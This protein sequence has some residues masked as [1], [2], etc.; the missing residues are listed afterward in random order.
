MPRVAVFDLQIQ[1]SSRILRAGTHGR[2]I[3][4]TALVNPAASTMQFSTGSIL[5]TEGTGSQSVDAPV[6]VTRSGDTSF[7]ASVNYATSDTSGANGCGQNTGAASSR[8]DYIATSGTLNFAAGQA[9]QTI[10]I[11]ITYD[12]Y[13][14]GPET[15]TLTLS[16]PTGLNAGLGLPSTTA[17]TINDSGFTGPN[18]IDTAGFF[19]R[20]HY[21]DFLNREP[22][23]SGLSFWTNQMTNCGAADLTVC[24]INVSG[25]FFQSIEFQQT[26]YLVERI[27][28]A[29]YG[30]PNGFSTFGGPHNFAVPVVRF[31]EFLPDSQEIG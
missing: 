21:V 7:P 24:R 29:A 22:D 11:P 10:S 23:A 15:F 20:Q 6:T 1:P 2:G 28:K 13:T 3:W 18:Q 16:S 14:E 4:E 31:N 25:A 30:D 27:Y 8:C 12:S 26:G 17:I 19:V 9:S 5:V